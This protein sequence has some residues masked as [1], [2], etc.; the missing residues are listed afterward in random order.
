M[1][2]VNENCRFYHFKRNIKNKTL[3][4]TW[5]FNFSYCQHSIH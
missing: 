1:Y 5:W 4:Q 2:F 3:R